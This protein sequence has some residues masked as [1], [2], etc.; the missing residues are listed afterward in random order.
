MI[1]KSVAFLAAAASAYGAYLP[2]KCVP[3][4]PTPG[5]SFDHVVLISVDGMHQLDL[6]NYVAAKPNSA[7]AT[8]VNSGVQFTN[9]Q[10]SFPSDSFPGLA[11][12]LTGATVKT[13]GVWYDDSY[14]T[15][16]YAPHSNCT[17]G[18]GTE[19]L[20]D[21]T[22]DY[23]LSLV[24]GGGINPA[25]LPM[26]LD[27]YGQCVPVWPHEYFTANNIFEIVKKYGKGTTAWTDK[28][29][30]YE[31][32]N[33][34]SGTGCDDTFFPDI[35][36]DPYGTDNVTL[37]GL[38]DE[39]HMN[40][41]LNWIGGTKANSSGAF[42]VPAVFGGNLQSVSVGQKLT[43]GGYL[44]ANG[45]FTAILQEGLD[46]ADFV[47]GNIIQALKTAGIYE[48]TVII[49]SAKHGQSPIDPEAVI[50]LD[51]NAL[52]AGAGVEVAQ[53]TSDDVALFWLKDPTQAATAAANLQANG[54]FQINQIWYGD[55]AKAL[56]GNNTR[57][58]DV[59][60]QPN[61]GVIY[62]LSG[63]KHAEHGGG[64]DDDR[65][66]LLVL[67]NPTFTPRSDSTPVFTTQIAPTILNLLGLPYTD[68]D[69]V[70]KEGTT[71]LP[72]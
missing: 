62:S 20:L 3:N 41:I 45:T 5:Y 43:A 42:S 18:A 34:P 27:Q 25:N 60:I 46:H 21:E 19:V 48:R 56:F 67:S 64:S 54:T 31:W 69:G 66:V 14:D 57:T 35:N 58:P 15:S 8:L 70:Q 68:L 65:H 6:V 55:A 39:L 29:P 23:D 16:L 38:Y 33:G 13:H 61:H 44:N 2:Y 51:P 12:Q 50:K 9:A 26:R 71:L 72:L 37:V 36:S 30:T 10:T 40:A 47:L 63:A 11:A 59:I 52:Q 49:V 4:P 17:G 32:V 24:S 22:V 7:F 28:H 1:A 53:L